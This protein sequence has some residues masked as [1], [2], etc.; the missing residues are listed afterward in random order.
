M[1]GPVK[2]MLRRRRIRKSASNVQTGFIPLA[3]KSSVNVVIDAEEPDFDKLKRDILTWGRKK[4]LEVGI[5]VFDF[6]KQGKDGVPHENDGTAILRKDLDW[7]GMPQNG[8][9]SG[10]LEEKSDVFISLIGNSCPTIDFLCK[11]TKARFKIGRHGYKGHA[12]D[13]VMTQGD[14]Q[15]QAGPGEI[16]SAITEF[17]DKIR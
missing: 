5:Y 17:I 1:F 16:F 6:R 10:L 3:E 12:F 9:V 7:L 15:E 2:N 13:M 8:K 4:W 14:T 11:C